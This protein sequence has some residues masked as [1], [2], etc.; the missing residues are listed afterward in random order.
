ME[1]KLFTVSIIALILCT[2]MVLADHQVFKQNEEVNYRFICRNENQTDFCNSSIIITMSLNYP[3]GTQI[4]DNTSLTHNPT[5]YN[6]TLPTDAIG[7]PY[8]AIIMTP[9]ASNS[10][11][12]FTYEVTPTGDKSETGDSILYSL[13]S[14]ILFG[15]ISTLSFFVFT[16]PSSNER[17]NGGFET[18]VVRLKYI[19]VIFVALIYGLMIML[20]NFLNALALNF[21]TLSVFSGILGFLFEIM[22]RLAWPF[23]VILIVWIVYMLIHDSN[24]KKKLKKMENM[25][26]FENE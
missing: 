14:A 11:V 22:L 26:L 21:T 20:F 7:Y 10:T 15:I 13:F 12:E 8:Q 5:Y 17:D 23:T 3:N 24:L 19:R 1:H 9:S 16:M 4:F 2:S 25:K 18:R 6:I